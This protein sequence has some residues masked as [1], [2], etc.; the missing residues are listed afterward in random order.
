[1]LE[2]LGHRSTPADSPEAALTLLADG[3]TVDL[4]LTDYYMPGMNGVELAEEIRRRWPAL[5]IGL[6]T[7]TLDVADS[8]PTLFDFV[9]AK[10]V[11]ATTLRQALGP[12][13][14]APERP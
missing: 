12:V 1:M 2:A 9:L 13:T 11:T 5:R 6:V 10:P 7:G 14:G 4:V 8:P 3:L